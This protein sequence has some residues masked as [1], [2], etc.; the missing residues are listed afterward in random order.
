MRQIVLGGL[1]LL[2]LL[3]V[4]WA[5]QQ[6]RPLVDAGRRSMAVPAAFG[7]IQPRLSPDGRQIVF[8]YQGA[9]W[10]MPRDSGPMT[11][12]TQGAGFDIE[13]VWS[14][15]AQLI[16]YVNSPRMGRGRLAVVHSQSALPVKLPTTVRVAETEEC[17][18][19]LDFHP[20]GRVLGNFR[21]DGQEGGLSLLDLGSGHLQSL[22]RPDLQSR[23]ALSPDG[24][25]LAY[26]TAMDR[27]GQQWGNDGPQVDIWKVSTTNAKKSKI[28]RFPS[29]VFDLCWSADDRALFVASDLGGAHNDLWY[30][31]IDDPERGARRITSG[32]A[33]E[34]RPSVDAEG[35][36]LLYTDNRS[37]AT[38]LVVRDLD[39]KI[40]T[41][42]E[43]TTIDFRQSTGTLR[44]SLRDRSTQKPVTARVSLRDDAGKFYAPPG[45]LYRVVEDHGDGH[46]Y[47][48]GSAELDLPAG[49]YTLRVFRGPEYRVARGS[50]L[51]SA[52]KISA[53][54]MNLERWTD[55]ASRGW[56]SGENHIHANYGY[57]EWYNTPQSLLEQCA[58]E[59]LRVCHF[60][61]AN[62]DTDGV[63]DREFFRGHPDA[64]ST[65]ETTLFWNQEFRS[66]LWGHMTLIGIQQL[67]E[68]VFTGF[69]DTTNPWDW[70]TN[71]EIADR[72]HLQ[73]AVANYTHAAQPGRPLSRRL[74][75]KGAPRRRGA[76]QDR[77]AR[78]QWRLRRHSPLVVSAAQLRFPVAGLGRDR[79]FSQSH[80]QPA[81]GGR[82][83]L[84]ESG[85]RVHTSGVAG[86]FAGRP[87]VRHERTDARADGRGPRTER[88]GADCRS[89]DRA[90]AGAGQVAISVKSHGSHL[91]R[92]GRGK[93]SAGRQSRDTRIGRANSG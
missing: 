11:R 50:F 4:A 13:P 19:K 67:V 62:S 1:T 77:H 90:R 48:T 87:L 41:T 56:Y 51:V 71:A 66:T 69:K 36:W 85:R 17:Y 73:H 35:R 42:L 20:D 18:A 43:P 14:R 65:Q 9:V 49:K 54:E 64:L 81:A 59:D 75:G 86:G 70:P 76:G 24:K 83:R 15:D 89:R 30:V 6:Q 88:H 45:A 22:A 68:P 25:W 52:G 5:S 44:L 79:L 60:M 72:T 8:S 93:R 2:A 27:E 33:D 58:G 63:F 3:L 37:G 46:F 16:A 10:R 80:S 47:C 78:S 39:R 57:G 28:T 84:R 74:Y 55:E 23:F 53:V 92:S 91:Q 26:T 61:V 12:L 38:A 34:D 31:P 21:V 7:P 29:R 82:S 32:Q 40:D